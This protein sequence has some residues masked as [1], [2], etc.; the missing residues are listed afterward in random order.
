MQSFIK[1]VK[2]L[3]IRIWIIWL[4]LSLAIVIPIAVSYPGFEWVPAVVISLVILA[5][6]IWIS[7]EV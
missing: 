4:V 6:I 7:M 2:E 3:P 1:A 5:S